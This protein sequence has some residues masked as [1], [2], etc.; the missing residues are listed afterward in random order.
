M[1]NCLKGVMGVRSCSLLVT[2]LPSFP[3]TRWYVQTVKLFLNIKNLK[4]SMNT[5]AWEQAKCYINFPRCPQT[6]IT[7]S[8]MEPCEV[9]W[10]LLNCWTLR[11]SECLLWG[12]AWC[13]SWCLSWTWNLW[14]KGR[15]D[16]V[17]YIFLFWLSTQVV[18]TTPSSRVTSGESRTYPPPPGL[19]TS[20]SR[21]SII[22]CRHVEFSPHI[23]RASL[24]SASGESIF[25]ISSD[26]KYPPSF[27]TERGFVAYAYHSEVDDNYFF[28]DE[29]IIYGSPQ[30]S[31]RHITRTQGSR[32]LDSRG[33]VNIATLVTMLIAILMLFV[34]YPAIAFYRNHGRNQLILT[35]HLINSTGQF[36]LTV[37]GTMPSTGWVIHGY[38]R[39]FEVYKM[40]EKVIFHFCG[41]VDTFKRI[42]P[43]WYERCRLCPDIFRWIQ[44]Y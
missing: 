2:N 3:A 42:C 43:H 14:L 13:W 33:F 36:P 17:I 20:S 24:G 41:S 6:K 9:L 23:L 18:M 30:Q 7:N 32:Y 44:L 34:V 11:A 40:P 12:V 27:Q 39:P 1:R 31:H 15:C 38:M 35:N 4:S 21:A 25:T 5:I 28:D 26:S 8:I 29:D 19:N 16:F 10:M 22:L 37:P